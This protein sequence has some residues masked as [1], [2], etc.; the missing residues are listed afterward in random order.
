MAPVRPNFLVLFSFEASLVM[1]DVESSQQHQSSKTQQAAFPD[2]G[3]PRLVH[4]LGSI[5][6][7]GYDTQWCVAVWSPFLENKAV[8][9]ICISDCF[10]L[11]PIGASEH[12]IFAAFWQRI[13]DL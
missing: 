6:T 4:Q 13:Q 3:H 5:R 12:A 7:C 10:P 11:F 1:F 9:F 2:T 8:D